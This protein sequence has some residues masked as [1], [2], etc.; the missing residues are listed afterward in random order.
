MKLEKQYNY[1]F[2][3][4]IGQESMKEAILLNLIDPALG[5]VLIRGQKG[6]AKTTAV[7]GIADLMKTIR[8]VEIPMNATEDRVAGTLDFEAALKEGEKQFQPGLLKEAD[9]NILYVDEVNL[10]DDH[11]VDLLLDAAA[12]GRNTVERE[13]ISF[14][15]EARFVLIGSMNPEEGNLR[16]QLLDRFGMVVDVRSEE[17]V[18]QRMKIIENRLDFEENP[19]DF[20]RKHARKQKALLQEIQNARKLLPGVK[21]GKDM[22]RLAA[23]IGIAYGTEGHRA[24]IGMIRTARTLAALDGRKRVKKKDIHRAAL[25]VLPHRMRKNPLDNGQMNTE[26][27]EQLTGVRQEPPKVDP[28]DG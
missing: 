15:H 11:L 7:R 28:E 6:T 23:E 27:L 25:Y 20:C 24:D 26:V 8:V 1:P 10:L 9:G 12:T 13:G 3:A 17:D 5:G 22:V 16:P 19:Q 4:I 18:E 2:T 14:T 21:A